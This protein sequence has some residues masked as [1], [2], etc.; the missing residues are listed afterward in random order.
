M[1]R[2]TSFL[3]QENP[4]PKFY[5]FLFESIITKFKI[6]AERLFIKQLV[7]KLKVKPDF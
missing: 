3:L 2:L 5:V 6:L 1:N 4:G 7:R